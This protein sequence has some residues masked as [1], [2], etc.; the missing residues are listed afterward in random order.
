MLGHGALFAGEHRRDPQREALL[1][2][3]RVAAVAGPV[4]PD[5]AGLGEMGDVFVLVRRPGHVGS[6]A[7]VGIDQWVADRV[8]G[9]HPR[10]T[11]GDFLH[12]V[13]AD[14]RHDVHAEQDVGAVGD[15]DADAGDGASQGAHRERND[16]H[17]PPAH[18]AGEQPVQGLLHLGGVG[19]VVGGAGLLGVVRAD[20]GARFDAGHVG[21]G[22][23]GEVGPGPLLRVEGD[24]RAGVDHC[25]GHAR[26]LLLRAVDPLDGV[27]LGQCCHLV[28]PGDEVGGGVGRSVVGDGMD[29]HVCSPFGP[30]RPSSLTDLT[31]LIAATIVPNCPFPTKSRCDV[32][33]LPHPHAGMSGYWC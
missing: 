26:L 30:G 20:E 3:Q 24:E 9:L 27:G 32:R 22:G 11:V 10:L 7:A 13:R 21:F 33:T 18:G 8:D 19:P 14:A 25:L 2:Q 29:G 5:L 4:R 31:C 23:A 1:A 17:R 28:D 6:G 12:D 16:V 15:L